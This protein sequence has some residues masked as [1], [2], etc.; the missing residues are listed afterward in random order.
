MK[1]TLALLLSA[2]WLG[3][4]T[5]LNG[6]SGGARSDAARCAQNWRHQGFD[7][8]PNSMTCSEMWVRAAA[9]R[10][11]AYW[12]EKGYTLDP[13]SMTWQQMD[14]KV[15]E[16]EHAR[17]RKERGH[18]SDPVSRTVEQPDRAFREL[19]E[20]KFT[21][22]SAYC[23]DPNSANPSRCLAAYGVRADGT[24]VSIYEP[25]APPQPTSPSGAPGGSSPSYSRS[26]NTS[27]LYS[28]PTLR[29]SADMSANVAENGSYYGQISENTG[30]PKTVH[31]RGY[32]RRDGT[33]VRSH[34]RSK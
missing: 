33:Y 24:E 31:V 14:Q 11:A 17:Y 34:F 5:A 13:N 19:C 23:N 12:E 9:I 29:P 10:R 1:R 3:G 21:R 7:F 4:C 20:T 8:D 30:R 6:Q 27:P 2:L 25:V 18:S 16:V 26:S 28:P 15:H 32:Y 22:G